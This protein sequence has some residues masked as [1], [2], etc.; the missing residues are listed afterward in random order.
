MANLFAD[1]IRYRFISYRIHARSI[2]SLVIHF[3]QKM[4]CIQR[5]SIKLRR[6][7]SSD[8]FA[9][10]CTPFLLTDETNR[11]FIHYTKS[12]IRMYPM[13]VY[14][15]IH[16]W[17]QPHSLSHTHTLCDSTFSLDFNGIAQTFLPFRLVLNP[18]TKLFARIRSPSRF[19]Q[20]PARRCAHTK[21]EAAL[22]IFSTHRCNLIR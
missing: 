12:T 6:H 11:I 2:I 20:N 4:F 3:P 21:A 1:S 15:A 10:I 14:N 8:R 17:A 22:R 16:R 5:G 7:R 9:S 19:A 13:L 18:L